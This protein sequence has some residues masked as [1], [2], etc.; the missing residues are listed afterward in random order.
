MVCEEGSSTHTVTILV[1][2]SFKKIEVCED[3]FE[4]IQELKHYFF[5]IEPTEDPLF[6]HLFPN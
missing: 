6:S 1:E 4:S 2:N 3:D 5:P